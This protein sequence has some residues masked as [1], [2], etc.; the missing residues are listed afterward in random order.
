LVA[1]GQRRVV[2]T[3]AINIISIIQHPANDDSTAL[4]ETFDSL[5]EPT[6]RKQQST[7]IGGNACEAGQHKLLIVPIEIAAMRC[8]KQSES[9]SAQCYGFLVFA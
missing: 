8:R 4:L 9:V 5:M 3:K 7:K 2:S 1:L 6:L